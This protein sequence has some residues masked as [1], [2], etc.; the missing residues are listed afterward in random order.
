MSNSVVQ[1]KNIHIYTATKF[2]CMHETKEVHNDWGFSFFSFINMINFCD[3]ATHTLPAPRQ[4]CY[5]TD[6]H[7]HY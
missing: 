6:M 4:R 7:S 3:L 2:I 5:V 1:L